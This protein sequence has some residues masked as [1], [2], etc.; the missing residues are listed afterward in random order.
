MTSDVP[1][2]TVTT[3]TG[4]PLP[5][6]NEHVGLAT[7]R[8]AFFSSIAPNERTRSGSDATRLI[9][10]L[11][12]A[13]TIILAY[14]TNPSFERWW[15][16]LAVPPPSGAAWLLSSLF[17]M[18]TAGAAVL[19]AL[20]GLL[21]HRRDLS[22]D[23]A[24]GF[25]A[26][27]VLSLFVQFAL[28]VSVGRPADR[29]FQHVNVGFPVPVLV[30]VVS[31]GIVGRPYFARDVRRFVVVAIAAGVV[32]AMT[33]GRALPLALVGSLAMGWA[34]ASI[35]RLVLGRPY[36]SASRDAVHGALVPM[37]LEVVAIS[38]TP[39]DPER[40]AH[41]VAEWGVERI[42]VATA[43]GGHHRVS[44]YGRDTRDAELLSS[45]WRLVSVRESGVAPFLGRQQQA[46]HEALAMAT[47]Y[48]IT[49]GKSPSLEGLADTSTNHDVLVVASLPNG[50]TLRERQSQGP[51]NEAELRSLA[52]LLRV[53]HGRRVALGTIDLDHL[54]LAPD[55]TAL[56]DDTLHAELNA[57]PNALSQD[58]ASLLTLI[59]LL[60][61]PALAVKIVFDVY[62]ADELKAT[63][64][65]LQK[66][67]LNARL[68]R[69]IKE[70]HDLL[71]QL[72]TEGAKAVG[73]EE[74]KLAQLKRVSGATLVL[75]IGSLVGGWALIGVF[76]NVASSFSTLRGA[77]WA[78]V[79]L[80]FLLSLFTF[81][82]LGVADL[83]SVTG[84]LPVLR[85]AALELA[86]SF[87]G[88]A[89]GTVA[90]V[91]AR[92]RFFQREGY[93]STA[94]LSSGVLASMSSWIV[95]GL[96]F[97]MALPFAWHSIHLTTSPKKGGSH[98][99]LIADVLIAVIV[100]ALVATVIVAV[101]KWRKIV[102][103]KLAPK[104]HEIRTLLK[105]LATQPRKLV[106]IFGGTLVAQLLVVFALGTSLHAFG[107]HLPIATL[108]VILTVGSVI[109]GVS[110]VPGGVGV[111]EAGMILG[112][113]AAGVSQPIAV[114]AVFVQRLFTSY[115]PPVAGYVTL[116]WMRRRDYL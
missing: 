34:A 113:T 54:A 100:V 102:E 65:F 6:A 60:S 46:E 43:D 40:A 47:V 58:L 53:V 38:P 15:V 36:V 37:G 48:D 84:K 27:L 115:L 21:V 16:N 1:A 55:G 82:A 91:A 49:H 99:H 24:S 31:M 22:T 88:L 97:L 50:H 25:A 94:A 52:T 92:V 72:R 67:A 41:H 5:L 70:D 81:A 33:T 71:E 106:E 79:V 57:T 112:L 32:G 62:G 74:P 20:F 19:L 42:F 93:D 45:T 69:E 90:V 75:G 89:I 8:S 86:N 12:L 13:L 68:R 56:I 98:G 114:A 77:N 11:L 95:K 17:L 76:L 111:V 64:A 51:L 96:L 14:R 87:S 83:G 61:T 116:L 23:L 30:A 80:T 2:A 44:V 3:T 85:L 39:L 66:P 73:V 110:P 105:T 63:L 107:A 104:Y 108:V 9:V 28:G 18:G 78:W 35:V 10:S 59:G 103:E 101:P 7:W 29:F 109:G 4:E 26:G